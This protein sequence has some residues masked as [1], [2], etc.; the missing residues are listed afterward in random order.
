[1]GKDFKVIVFSYYSS[2]TQGRKRGTIMYNNNGILLYTLEWLLGLFFSFFDIEL[3]NRSN[4]PSL[5][6]RVYVI[7]I[8]YSYILLIE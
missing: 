6:L 8:F 2:E 7:V 5:N 3:K 1:M 4:W